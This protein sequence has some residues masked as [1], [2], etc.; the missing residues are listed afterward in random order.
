MLSDKDLV[1]DT[2]PIVSKTGLKQLSSYIVISDF[3]FAISSE[4]N[5]NSDMPFEIS[6]KE[7]FFSFQPPVF[8][9]TWNFYLKNGSLSKAR[10]DVQLKIVRFEM[11]TERWNYFM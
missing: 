10:D 3:Q 11:E 5:M 1:L 6:S 8:S 7:F 4:K 9:I 2:Q